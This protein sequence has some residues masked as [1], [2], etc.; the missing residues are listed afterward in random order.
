MKVFAVIVI[1]NGMQRNWIQKCFDSLL[2]STVP[3]NIVAIDNGSTDESIAYVKKQY[4]TVH[5]IENKQNSGFAKANNLGIKIAKQ[6]NADY[7]FLLNQDA[8]LV[9][10]EDLNKLIKAC[11]LCPEFGIISPVHLNGAGIALDNNFSRYVKDT[12][13]EE[14]L[15]KKSK[16]MEVFE[17]AFVNAAAWL[18]TGRCIMLLGGFDTKLFQ[19]YG[20]DDNYIQRVKYL[21]L[22]VGVL[23]GAFICHDRE[24]R[25]STGI[26]PAYQEK[27]SWIER[28][29]A[30]S[31]VFLSA[32][33]RIIFVLRLCKIELFF[34]EKNKK[35]NTLN[36]VSLVMKMLLFCFFVTV[37]GRKIKVKSIFL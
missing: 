16:N 32:W 21:K 11:Q 27:M 33:S 25:S 17:V 5:L 26:N 15:F 37:R 4:P 6:A 3:I 35:R 8:W 23:P 24:I 9:G 7:V 13:S 29:V 30:I 2:H 36:S 28:K 1:Y 10:Q 22:K 14:I 20:E 18:I 12:I 34:G 31:N 19:H